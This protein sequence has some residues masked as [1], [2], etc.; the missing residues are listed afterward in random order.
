MIAVLWGLIAAVLVGSSDAIARKTS[1]HSD[2]NVLTLIVM[3][4]STAGMTVWFIVSGDWPPWH[5][6]AWLA[7]AA[8]GALNIVVLYFLYLA[9]RRGPVSVASPA[10]STFTVMLVGLNAFA[11]EPWTLGQLVAVALVFLGVVML[12]RRSS[13][14]GIDD[15]YDA[16]WIQ[17]T[18]LIGLIAAFAVSVRMFLAQDASAVLGAAGALYLN[19]VF[20]LVTASLL[21]L[22]LTVRY[23]KTESALHWPRG[24][25]VWLIALQAALETFAL[26]AFLIGSSGNGRIGAS[27]G[28]SA[29]AAVTAIVASLWL[30]ERIGRTR[31]LWIAVVVAGLMLASVDF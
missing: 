8:S 9:L 15:A 5:R 12:A 29:F 27:I 23:A 7:S 24:Q 4:L 28:F 17:T 21:V 11:G 10:A 25:T 1:Q 2:L 22:A 3:A 26:G 19:R 30:G 20:A 13:T 14:P 31:A 18:A 16:R 6:N